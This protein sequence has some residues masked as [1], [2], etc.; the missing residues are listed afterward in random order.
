MTLCRFHSYLNFIH[1]NGKMGRVN[2]IGYSIVV[3]LPDFA[4]MKAYAEYGRL[5]AQPI[6]T[7]KKI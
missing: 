1:K 3:S 4:L 6:L 2:F 5:V 7:R